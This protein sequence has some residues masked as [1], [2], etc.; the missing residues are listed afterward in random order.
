VVGGAPSDPNLPER[1]T[2]RD[3]TRVVGLYGRG[4]V[5][6]TIMLRAKGKVEI[7]GVAPWAD[8]DWYVRKAIHKI[9]LGDE[10]GSYETEF[11]VTR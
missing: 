5:T 11:E 10:S 1:V 7:L 8:G 3:P 2:R 4:K 6:G 9:I